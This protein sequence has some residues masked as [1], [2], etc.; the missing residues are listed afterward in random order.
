MNWG[1]I[2]SGL[3]HIF[4]ISPGLAYMTLQSDKSSNTSP[5]KTTKKET[6]CFSWMGRTVWNG[7]NVNQSG[8][9]HL[10][11]RGKWGKN[12]N[13]HPRLVSK[14]VTHYFGEPA[15]STV[16]GNPVHPLGR[17]RRQQI[18][19]LPLTYP[20]PDTAHWGKYRVGT[21]TCPL[22]TALLQREGASMAVARKNV[23]RGRITELTLP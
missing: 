5:L 23:W 2:R 6:S 10:I 3:R 1:K 4:D 21:L 22:T 19:P 11:S 13:T 17:I 20:N 12:C 9:S 16:A 7:A 8:H 14:A 15:V 18:V